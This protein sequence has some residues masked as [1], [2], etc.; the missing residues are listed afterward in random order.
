MKNQEQ[1]TETQ[2]PKPPRLKTSKFIE[3]PNSSSKPNKILQIQQIY[4]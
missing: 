1:F 4:I 2:I 3:S